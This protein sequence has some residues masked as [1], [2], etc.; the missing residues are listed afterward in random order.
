MSIEQTAY[1]WAPHPLDAW[2]QAHLLELAHAA[3]ES[4]NQ[5]LLGVDFGNVELRAPNG[6]TVVVFMDGG[7]LDYIDQFVTPSGAKLDVWPNNYQSEQWPPVMC[8]RGPDDTAR[9]RALW[10]G[11]ASPACP[12]AH[13]P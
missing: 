11:R 5:Q 6:W 7:E 2:D 3:V 9:L 8:W 10:K 13:P 12:P 4:G 1:R